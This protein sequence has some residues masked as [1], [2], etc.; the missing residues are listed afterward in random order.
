MDTLAIPQTSHHVATHPESAAGTRLRSIDILRGLVIVIMAFDHV[1]D[2]FTGVRFDPLDPA[3]TTAV[4]YGTRWITHF[5][6][7]VF[8]LL[9]G[10]S[11]YLTGQRYTRSQLS[12]FLV[13]RG[14][15]LI[16]LEFTVVTLAWTFNFKYQLGLI[17]QVIWAIGA[18]MIV[19]AALIRLPTLVVG[20]IGLT[21]C[22]L[23]NLLDSIAPPASALWGTVWHILHVQGSTA[24]GYVHFPLIPWV[25]VMALGYALGSVYTVEP[26][27]RRRIF[28]T[29]GVFAIVMFVL[30]RLMNG[31]GDPQP[32]TVQADAGRTLMSFLNVEKYPP[33]LL[34]LLVTVG[35]ALLLLAALEPARKARGGA[36][37]SSAAQST[38]RDWF[39]DILATYGRVPLFFYVLHIAL[40][41][42]AA[43]LVALYMGFGTQVLT[44]FFLAFP[45][46]WGVGFPVVVLEWLFVVIALYPACRWFAGLKRRRNEWWLAYL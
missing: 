12:R 14:L 32:W 13:T 37:A 34:Y 33:S 36:P 19:L 8:I 27:I 5:C 45:P 17:M 2:Y 21:I 1:R 42:L 40:A 18:S 9:A 11:A 43:G 4:F 15:W 46:A 10:V 31:Y 26:A 39:A 44:N 35:P 22:C 28:A 20:A 25:G 30:L 6:A 3:Q 29:F 16:A 41:H 7:P 38:V 23:H 24:I